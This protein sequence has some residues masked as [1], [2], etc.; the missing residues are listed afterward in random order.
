MDDNFSNYICYRNFD[1]TKNIYK[2]FII[3][4]DLMNT[5]VD[6]TTGKPKKYSF[7]TDNWLYSIK[8]LMYSTSKTSPY[9]DVH[10]LKLK[11]LTN[12]TRKADYAQY[13]QPVLIKY[14]IQWINNYDIHLIINEHDYGFSD[15]SAFIDNNEYKL[16]V[17]T[18]N[19]FSLDYKDIVDNTLEIYS[20]GSRFKMLIQLL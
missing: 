13:M 20:S 2:T 7:S 9:V 4:D 3:D 5:N 8:K 6:N 19:L 11:M 12:A 10:D 16:Q 18:D 15:V 1:I 14:F 17:I